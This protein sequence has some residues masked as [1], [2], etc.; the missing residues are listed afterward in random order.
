MQEE[1][2]EDKRGEEDDEWTMGTSSW[3]PDLSVTDSRNFTI[4][5]CS[6]PKVHIVL[7]ALAYHHGMC[8]VTR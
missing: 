2:K 1:G 3:W 7:L 4:L 5:L 8:F 6:S